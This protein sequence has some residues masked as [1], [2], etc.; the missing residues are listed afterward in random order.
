MKPNFLLLL[1]VFFCFSAASF[2]KKDDFEVKVF[3]QST[4]SDKNNKSVGLII[5]RRIGA[6]FDT[7]QRITIQFYLLKCPKVENCRTI[8]DEYAAVG[9]VKGKKLAKT[10]MLA[11]RINLAE[12]YW[13][14]TMSSIDGMIAQNFSKVSKDNKY[15]YAEIEVCKKSETK[16]AKPACT[17]YVSN[18]IVL[19]LKQ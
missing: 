3:S 13:R 9:S 2:A 6:D 8:D 4:G 11:L 12:F 1:I 14:P 7:K 10:E 18:E 5:K 17:S 15:F 19:N 16:N